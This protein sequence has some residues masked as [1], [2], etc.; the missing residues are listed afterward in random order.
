MNLI[1]G[2]LLVSMVNSHISD[3]TRTLPEEL[4]RE[5][6]TMMPEAYNDPF[7][8]KR[9]IAILDKAIQLDS[10]NPA[11]YMSQAGFYCQ[12]GLRRAALRVLARLLSANPNVV[13][14]LT[15]QGFILERMG[16]Q[17]EAREKYL[18]EIA[19][20]SRLI[21][22]NG[23]DSIQVTQR[24]ALAVAV[25]FAKGKA[26]GVLEYNKILSIYPKNTMVLFERSLFYDFDRKSLLNGW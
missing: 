20:C 25:L 13:G 24:L 17:R 5:A 7:K 19:L 4:V 12:L 8:S 11:P 9:V 15:S 1:F 2:F 23:P 14:A 22:Q 18:K 3:T 6:A 10:L 21:E 26:Q 16:K